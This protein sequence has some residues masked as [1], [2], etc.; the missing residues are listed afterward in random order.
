MNASTQPHA[1]LRTLEAGRFVASFCV[2]LAH[3]VQVI[4]PQWSVGRPVTLFG[5]IQAPGALAV[6]YFFVL[7]GFVM[8]TAHHA[9]F[10]DARA[11]VRFWLRRAGRIYPVYWL[12]LGIACIY[13]SGLMVGRRAFVVVTLW[14]LA[15][16]ADDIIASAWTLRFEIVFYLMFGLA[17]LPKIGRP[18]LCAWV[19]VVMWTTGRDIVHAAP[20]TALPPGFWSDAAVFIS[21]F[22][23]FFFAGVLAAWLLVA[24]KLRR[25]ALWALLV[26]GV[27]G[28]VALLPFMQYGDGY[29]TPCVMLLSS[30]SLGSTMLGVAGLERGRAIRVGP[31]AV[32]LGALAYPLYMLHMPL[33]L[34]M[35]LEIKPY[36]LGAPALYGLTALTLA[37]FLAVSACVA[38]GFDQPLQTLLRSRLRRVARR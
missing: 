18:L 28:L 2:V 4:V 23:L 5:G 25:A 20:W 3:F 10:G 22:N 26:F 38:F 30:V 13:L 35:Q 9:D 6:Q 36:P 8:M 32:W 15:A 14:P 31:W 21:P 1:T 34:V 11:A 33:Q 24:V 19:A 29:G 7:S 37:C 12:A 16:S 27:G 17:L